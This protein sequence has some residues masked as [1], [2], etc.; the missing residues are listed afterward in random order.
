MTRERVGAIVAGVV[1]IACVTTVVIANQTVSWF[2]L[3]LML[4]AL[5]G[6]ISLLALY[7]RKYR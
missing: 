2:N 3:A 6:L 7:N 1:F 5:A 4:I